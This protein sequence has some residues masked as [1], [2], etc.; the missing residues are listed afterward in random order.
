MRNDKDFDGEH[1][2]PLQTKTDY[3]CSKS[4]NLQWIDLIPQ[5]LSLCLTCTNS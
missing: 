2:D 3:S 5:N 1:K 4:N